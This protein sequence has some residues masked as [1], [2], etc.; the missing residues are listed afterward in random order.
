MPEQLFS[1]INN[2]RDG[3]RLTGIV[4]SV[5]SSLLAQRVVPQ[6]KIDTFFLGRATLPMHRS[7]SFFSG[8]HGA[9]YSWRR[10]PPEGTNQA[11]PLYDPQPEAQLQSNQAFRNSNRHPLGTYGRMTLAYG[12]T[13]WTLH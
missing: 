8:S 9:T 3:A 1:S 10:S 12:P 13:S 11:A 2:S 7:K 4:D 6:K 5:S